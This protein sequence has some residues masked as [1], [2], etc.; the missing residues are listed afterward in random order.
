M[1]R[2]KHSLC[3]HHYIL[4]CSYVAD[5]MKDVIA[6]KFP[7]RERDID[8]FFQSFPFT[9]V[10]TPES[11][12]KSD[13]PEIRDLSDL[14][15]LISAVLEDADILISGDNDF[16]AVDIEK[17]IILKPTEFLRLYG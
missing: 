16:S 11:F 13:F 2:L 12:D 8:E 15:I 17:P 9:L 6:R 5:E 1:N 7:G 14:P 10:Y 3:G 4:L